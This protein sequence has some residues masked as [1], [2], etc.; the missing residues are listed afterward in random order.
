MRWQHVAALFVAVVVALA[1]AAGAA[2]Q[3]DEQPTV[4]I[5]DIARFEGVFAAIEREGYRLRAAYPENQSWD[6]GLQ[7][8]WS[9]LLLALTPRRRRVVSRTLPTP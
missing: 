7:R 3:I 2:A 5:K 9:A 8:S 1:T 4:R 6:V